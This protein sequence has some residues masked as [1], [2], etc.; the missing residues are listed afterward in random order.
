VVVNLLVNSLARCHENIPAII[1]KLALETPEKVMFFRVF[2]KSGKGFNMVEIDGPVFISPECD[3]SLDASDP[4]VDIAL[5]L[6]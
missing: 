6:Q 1:M 2:T 5:N 3:I 4:F